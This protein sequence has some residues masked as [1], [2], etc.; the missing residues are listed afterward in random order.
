MAEA[1]LSLFSVCQ[2]MWVCVMHECDTP[3]LTVQG[4]I[5]DGLGQA[6]SEEIPLA[7]VFQPTL[8]LRTYGLMSLHIRT[9]PR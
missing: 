6:G 5:A 9:S 1:S 7:D 2:N 4:G 8:V 3:L